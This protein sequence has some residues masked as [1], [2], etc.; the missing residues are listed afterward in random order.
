ML[1]TVFAQILDMSITGSIVICVV[2]LARLVLKRMPKIFSYC[3]WG[4]VLLRLLCPVGI[5]LPVAPVPEMPTISAHYSLGDVDISFADAGAAAMDGIL[6]STNH[7]PQTYYVQIPTLQAS[8]APAAPTVTCAPWETWVLFGQY[9]WAAGV[10]L[11][12]VISLVQWIILR[13]KL[14]EALHLREN[15]YLADGI[16]TPFVMGCFRPRIYIPEGLTAQE[17]QHILLHEQHHI[18]RMDPVW[19]VL[20]YAAFCLH[21]FNPLVWLA[22]RLAVQDMEMSC[23]EAVIRGLG[24]NQRA[25]YS[26]SL[27]R[28]STGRAAI[29]G[30]PLSFGEGDAGKRIRN[31]GR[32]RQPARRVMSLVTVICLLLT[33]GCA[34]DVTD[35]GAT[36]PS[37]AEVIYGSNAEVIF[38]ND[39]K[40]YDVPKTDDFYLPEYPGVLFRRDGFALCIQEND[41]WRSLFYAYS[42]YV[43]DLNG[44]GKREFCGVHSVGSG[45]IDYRIVVYDYV[46]DMLYDLSER[47]Y[48]DYDLTVNDGQLVAIRSDHPISSNQKTPLE[49]ILVLKDRQLSFVSGDITVSGSRSSKH[50]NVAALEKLIAEVQRYAINNNHFRILSGYAPDYYMTLPGINFSAALISEEVNGSL[51]LDFGLVQGIEAEAKYLALLHMMTNPYLSYYG[52]DMRHY[53]YQDPAN[54]AQLFICTEIRDCGYRDIAEYY[55]AVTTGQCQPHEDTYIVRLDSR[56]IYRWGE[57]ENLYHD[58]AQ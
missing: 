41:T 52:G 46:D 36:N 9:L 2:L 23:D 40:N 10:V 29:A 8:Q 14:S 12:A 55:Q 32:Y 19:K 18:R 35:Q 5:P 3:L 47:G 7:N 24:S 22:F 1:D 20:G 33:V 44:D 4:V 42:I 6:H 38:D 31:L 58:D 13:K 53:T 39:D 15:I 50:F 56:A 17:Q 45:I 48:C 26:Q 25:D 16:G 49:G 30:V 43:A 57:S 27:L 11:W 34:V 51:W 21:W 54:P 28:F 37:D